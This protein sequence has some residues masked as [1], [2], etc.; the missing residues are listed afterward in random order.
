M[1][2]LGRYFLY[3]PRLVGVKGIK[4]KDVETYSLISIISPS[5]TGVR[6]V[7]YDEFS[8]NL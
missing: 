1:N 6:S 8:E 3:R 5:I 2:F 7:T 4:L